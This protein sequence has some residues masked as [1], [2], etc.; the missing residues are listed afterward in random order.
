[1]SKVSMAQYKKLE[2]RVMRLEFALASM[3]ETIGGLLGDLKPVEGK[4]TVDPIRQPHPHRNH[5]LH[6]NEVV[7]GAAAKA[8]MPYVPMR[9]VAK[10]SGGKGVKQ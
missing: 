6:R 10:A 8:K 7:Q 9:G 4:T 2:A 1:M 5:P 3:R